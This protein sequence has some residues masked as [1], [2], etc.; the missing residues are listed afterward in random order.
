MGRRYS[1]RTKKYP[2]GKS[3]WVRSPTISI[4]SPCIYQQLQKEETRNPH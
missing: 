1:E 3:K 2:L 4:E